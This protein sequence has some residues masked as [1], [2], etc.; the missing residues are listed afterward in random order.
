M[1]FKETKMILK[2]IQS[3][4]PSF[5][6]DDYKIKEWHSELKKYDYDDVNRKLEEHMRSTEYGSYEPKLYFLTKFLKPSVDKNKNEAYLI[7]CPFC[8]E[9]I[10]DEEYDKHYDR[11]SSIEFINR[12]CLEMTG[13]EIDRNKYKQMSEEDF[14]LFY[15]KLIKN[16][17]NKTKN[18]Q[19]K[20]AIIK[21]LET[22]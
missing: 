19:Q 11:C 18:E 1:E 12:Q 9:Y 17:Y 2:R 7:E 10:R 4:Y 8:G 13:K 20:N 6:L 5:M 22:A 14:E 3:Y 21:Y 16:V 15:Q